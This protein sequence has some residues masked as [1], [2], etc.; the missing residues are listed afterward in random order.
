MKI[1]KTIKIY[2]LTSIFLLSRVTG[3][4]DGLGEQNKSLIKEEQYTPAARTANRLQEDHTIQ[5]KLKLYHEARTYPRPRS[6]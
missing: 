5:L 2:I 3:G 6:M 4:E 1:V